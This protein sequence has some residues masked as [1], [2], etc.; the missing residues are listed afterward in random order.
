[1]TTVFPHIFFRIAAATLLILSALVI[2]RAPIA[3]TGVVLTVSGKIAGDRS[4]GQEPGLHTRRPGEDRHGIIRFR[5]QLD[6]RD[7]YLRRRT[8]PE[9]S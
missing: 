3:D 8:V 7:A 5:E 2:S 9:V 1:M 4:R 6:G